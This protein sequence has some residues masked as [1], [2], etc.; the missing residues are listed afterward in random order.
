MPLVGQTKV[1]ETVAYSDITHSKE[2][3][4][5]VLTFEIARFAFVNTVWLFRVELTKPEIAL[6][7][8]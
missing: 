4:M 1:E 3:L 8:L 5:D 6:R 2:I 7:C